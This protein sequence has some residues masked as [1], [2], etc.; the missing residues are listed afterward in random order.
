MR[1][2]AIFLP[3]VFMLFSAGRLQGQVME[4]AEEAFRLSASTNKPL[5]L[6]FAGS[7]WCAPC[8]RFN[9]KVLSQSAFINYAKENFILLKIDFPQRKRL[10]KDKSKRNDELAERYNPRGQFPHVLLLSPDRSI[11]GLLSYKNQTPEEFI[12]EIKPYFTE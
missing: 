2:A 8:I 3:F 11:L 10:S 1:K 7:D 12:S 9:D 4:N 5:L 6:I